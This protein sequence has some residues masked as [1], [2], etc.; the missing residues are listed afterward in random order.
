V[1]VKVDLLPAPYRQARRHHRR[2][3]VGVTVGAI[4]LVGELCTGL[5]LHNRAHE[6][7]GFQ[8]QARSARSCIASVKQQLVGPTRQAALINQQIT[9]AT[10][11][12]TTHRWSRLLAALAQS[13]PEKV[14]LTAVST[15]PPKWAPGL[16][17]TPKTG[18]G[19]K[20]GKDVRAKPLIEGISIQGYAVDHNDLSKFMAAVLATDAFAAV[21]LK[22]AQRERFLE[23]DAIKFEL[24]CHW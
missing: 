13:T 21:D 22:R 7:R 11:L 18:P 8:A 5:V 15:N 10:R 12:R 4:L 17:E 14:V 16:G 19:N 1:T 20:N 24:Q 9:L 6:T 23:Q 2:F 3:R